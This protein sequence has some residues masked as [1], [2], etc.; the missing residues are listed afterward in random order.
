MT[1]RLGRGPFTLW[2]WT[3]RQAHDYPGWSGLAVVILLLVLSLAM[4]AWMGVWEES[5]VKWL[6]NSFTILGGLSLTFGWAIALVAHAQRKDVELSFVHAGHVDPHPEFAAALILGSESEA[7]MEWQLRHLRHRR[8]EVVWTEKTRDSTGCAESLCGH[9]VPSWAGAL[10]T[11][12]NEPVRTQR[13]Q[14]PLPLAASGDTGT[15]FSRAGVRG[16][17]W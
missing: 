11:C 13:R 2:R 12:A 10:R 16:S 14:R 17:Y 6:S 4:G 7:L 3:L 9:R 15:F 8:V 1:L 5:W